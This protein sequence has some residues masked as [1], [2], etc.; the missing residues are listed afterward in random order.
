[1]QF[2]ISPW[3]RQ[4]QEFICNIFQN[5]T[6][7][8]VKR[9]INS[10]GFDNFLINC[11]IFYLKLL[12]VNTHQKTKFPLHWRLTYIYIYQRN[13]KSLTIKSL[14]ADENPYFERL[15]SD[16]MEEFGPMLYLFTRKLPY[17]KHSF[18]LKDNTILW[19]S[20]SNRNCALY[21]KSHQNWYD[22]P[23]M[24][25][26]L[27]LYFSKIEK[28]SQVYYLRKLWIIISNKLICVLVILANKFPY[29]KKTAVPYYML[30]L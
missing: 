10:F 27:T 5:W 17:C 23:H 24:V 7:V 4:Y 2:Q 6:L 21:T 22:D 8:K 26:L 25:I 14:L 9:N 28:L 19:V 20:K 18:I 1:M 13:N 16:R 29:D 11:A 30:K 15:S 12:K 3:T